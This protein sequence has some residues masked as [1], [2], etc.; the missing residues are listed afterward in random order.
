MPVKKRKNIKKISENKQPKTPKLA[1][2]NQRFFNYLLDV[3]FLYIFGFLV[4]LVGALLGFGSYFHEVP[5]F[6]F[7]MIMWFVYYLISEFFFGRTIGKLFTSTKVL[8]ED[9]T[10]LRFGGTLKRTLCRFIPFDVFS[11]MVNP[12]GWHDKFSKTRVVSI[13]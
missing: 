4:G 8:N 10:Q 9:G 6:V 7:G 1:T 2:Q 3:I 5:H 13:K 11:Y 12:I